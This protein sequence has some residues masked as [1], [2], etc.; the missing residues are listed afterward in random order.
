MFNKIR[1]ISEPKSTKVTEPMQKY[2]VRQP[3]PGSKE[4]GKV[5]ALDCEM[6]ECEDELGGR[7]SKLAR[8]SV[9]NYNGYVIWD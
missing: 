1:N 6:V 7:C 8:L 5:I 3:V 4:A 2:D 9:V